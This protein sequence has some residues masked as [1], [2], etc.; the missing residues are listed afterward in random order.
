MDSREHSSVDD[1]WKREKAIT[2][3]DGPPSY[4]EQAGWFSKILFTWLNPL[5]EKGYKKALNQE[6]LPQLSFC[7]RNLFTA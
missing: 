3:R 2:R 1:M 5:L 7:L 4:E 6:D